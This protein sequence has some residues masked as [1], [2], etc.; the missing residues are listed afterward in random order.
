MPSTGSISER[1]FLTP[2]G[3]TSTLTTVE[4][5]MRFLD[6][7]TSEVLECSWVGCGDDPADKGLYKAMTGAMRTFLRDF[8]LLPQGDDPEF[9]KK[10]DERGAGRTPAPRMLSEDQCQRVFAAFVDAGVSDDQVQ[11]YLSAAGVVDPS[12]IT[13]EQSQELASFLKS[14]GERA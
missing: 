9:D 13:V 14:H 11:T 5:T 3:K 7:E 12:K 4:F 2:R 10:A 1:D 6:A 8:F